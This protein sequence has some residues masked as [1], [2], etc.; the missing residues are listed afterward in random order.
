M[1]MNGKEIVLSTAYLAP[2]EYYVKLYHY[3]RVWVEGFDHYAKQTYR[4]RCVIA[5]ADGPL[6]LTIPTEKGEADKLLT[7][8]VRISDHGNWRRVHWNAFEAAYRHSPFFDYYADEFHRFF[9]QRYTFLTD[10]NDAL[11]RWVCEQVG[12][13][14]DIC[15]T[16]VYEAAT[17]GKEDFRERIHP[18]KDYRT[19]DPDFV[20]V[21]YYQ[22]FD[23]RNGF[24]PN[25]SVADLLFNMGPESLLVLRDS[26]AA[27]SLTTKKTF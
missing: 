10:F 3:D 5:A 22:V 19:T 15:P 16:T 7:R 26:V 21:V 18:K 24:L 23:A 4:N 6:A 11:C 27:P 1:K 9:E 13:Q 12:L 17:A 8:D 25:L 14:P 2:V 20:P